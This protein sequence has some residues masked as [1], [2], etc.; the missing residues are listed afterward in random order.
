MGE[1]AVGDATTQLLVAGIHEGNLEQVQKMLKLD[2]DLEVLTVANE[3]ARL[4]LLGLAAH[5]GHHHLVAPLVSAG[6]DVNA[7]D[8]SGLTPLIRAARESHKKVIREL[9]KAGADINATASEKEM[10]NSV[11]HTCIMKSDEESVTFLLSQEG[12]NVSLQ[13]DYGYTP[14]HVAAVV[15]NVRIINLL[16]EAGAN[17]NIRTIHGCTPLHIASMSGSLEAVKRLL[18][19]KLDI[20]A[21]D[22]EGRTPCD[23]ADERGMS[24]V[25]W[26]FI[27]KAGQIEK[28][29][30]TPPQKCE[31]RYE[32]EEW[33]LDWATSGHNDTLPM[34][35]Y[36]HPSQVDSYYQDK[37][38]YTILHM[39]AEKGN[40]EMLQLLIEKCNIYPGVVDLKNRTAADVARI[41][42]FYNLAEYIE[43]YLSHPQTKQE[44]ESLYLQLLELI[45]QGD[46]E[47]KASALLSRGSPVEPFGQHA[48]HAL[49]L[50]ITANR[51]KILS[52][53]LAA[54]APITTVFQ[55]LNILQI[56]WISPQISTYTRM[57]I[58]RTVAHVLEEELT[59]VDTS[60]IELREGI[61]H[62]VEKVKSDTP[63]IAR[64][65]HNDSI[66]YDLS[67]KPLACNAVHD[68]NP[69]FA[70]SSDYLTHLM[71]QAVES[72]CGLTVGFLQQ[73]G[74]IPFA[75]D[76]KS[77]VSP[78]TM[79][80]MCQHWGIV[81]QLAQGSAC[82][83]I[84]DSSG[85]YPR[86]YLPE[87]YM[88]ELEKEV[89]DREARKIEDELEKTR[90][91]SM[92][93]EFRRIQELHST[94]FN[95]YIQKDRPK[96]TV[97]ASDDLIAETLQLASQQ[98]LSQLIHFLLEILQIDVN[99]QVEKLIGTT[100]L[101]QAA[102]FGHSDLC[103]LLR[104]R[105]AEVDIKDHFLHTPAHFAAMFGH[106]AAYKQLVTLMD[107]PESENLSNNSPRS[108][109]NN[110][111]ILLDQYG[112]LDE[113][114]EVGDDVFTCSDPAEA[115]KRKLD[116]M[117]LSYIVEQS[118]HLCV[119]FSEGEAAEVKVV[120]TAEL[121]KIKEKIS[122]VNPLFTGRLEL[123]G[124][125]ADKT[126]LH[127]PDEFDFNFCVDTETDLTLNVVKI[128]NKK[129]ALLKGH[130]KYLEVSSQN[131][132]INTLLQKSNWKDEFYRAVAK[133]MEGHVFSDSRLSLVP[134]GVTRTQV[135][136]GISLSWQGLRY[137]IL[138][139]GIDLVPVL[140]ASWPENLERPYLT[141]PPISHVYISSIGDGAWRL[142]FANLEADILKSL[143]PEELEV[144]LTCKTLLSCM[145]AEPWMPKAIKNK[146]TWWSSRR[147]K[148][149]IPSG[150]ALKNCF[151]RQLEKKKRNKAT[152]GR[153]TLAFHM[154]DVFKLMVE[155]EL[156]EVTGITGL[157]GKK[158]YA[159]FGGKFEQPKLGE[160]SLEIIR[161]LEKY[162]K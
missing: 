137:P 156:Y 160:G 97:R 158:I 122:Q 121:E 15:N 105:G 144:Y 37:R 71:V 16:V 39:A 25:Y 104:A 86:D 61:S 5:F 125:A 8:S 113:F 115:E 13:D 52:L 54:G 116:Q 56:A 48:H 107:N 80:V 103:V 106:E 114:L 34:L 162:C 154:L 20:Y 109:K 9:V 143:E 17:R 102:A 108:M 11:L 142:S 32:I 64:W 73:A 95:I 99:L 132:T 130:E 68:P 12:L 50:A 84:P 65:P 148:I 118:H 78:F 117:T 101:H 14:L 85:Y 62:I 1:H 47:R 76:P 149:P 79:A 131:E 96:A 6:L 120:V 10:R 4:S 27:K 92:K 77:E 111:C 57:I 161:Y 58:T 150:F 89:F 7:R 123:L 94:L 136:V 133:S 44:K 38:G 63:W 31:Q 33:I 67:Q 124:S 83:Y 81:R 72:N 69:N 28:T 157:V 49:L 75:P 2:V 66:R 23:L 87:F 152:W 22:N 141:P 147:W 55:G 126:R 134:P 45:G 153:D 43:S 110:F 51:R 127:A 145:K 129:E 41:Q 139:I 93:D 21:V 30:L 146:F 36:N 119:N 91:Q 138:L 98:G 18:E 42:G 155:K 35:Q 29:V 88:R 24:E 70:Y 82:L 60:N 140:K 112:V 90:E 74:G 128:K 151:L 3:G 135:G 59:R 19:L 26:F 100:A 53:L 159:Y 40:R 46:E